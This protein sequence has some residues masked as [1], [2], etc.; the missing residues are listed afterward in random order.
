MRWIFELFRLNEAVFDT[1]MGVSSSSNQ[2]RARRPG[3]G[4]QRAGTTKRHQR[5]GYFHQA[6]QRCDTIPVLE[7]PVDMTGDEGMFV[8]DAVGDCVPGEQVE[9]TAS[10]RELQVQ[11]V[12][13]FADLPLNH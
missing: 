9:E 7:H 6:G 12:Y 3:G 8:F 4:R 11:Y 13:V 2:D 5:G 1:V 10:Q